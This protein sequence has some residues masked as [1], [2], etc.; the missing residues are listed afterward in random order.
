MG[1]WSI[2]TG[3]T[4]T[5]DVIDAGI[6]L[7]KTAAKG[8]DMLVY[9]DEEKAITGAK[10]MAVNMAQALEFAKLMQGETGASAVTR[11]IVACIVMANFSIFA[12][13][14]S[15]VPLYWQKSSGG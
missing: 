8:L 7:T 2:I 12:L 13:T 5:A 10:N 4:K 3:A 1:L 15:R 11:R 6:D 14:F 9:T